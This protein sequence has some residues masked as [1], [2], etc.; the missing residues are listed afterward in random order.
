MAASHIQAVTADPAGSANTLVISMAAVGTGSGLIAVVA[1]QA[2]TTIVSI[3]D[4]AA[5]SPNAGKY[6]DL[7]KLSGSSYFTWGI[8]GL[9]IVGNPTSLTVTWNAAGD[10]RHGV[11]YEGAGLALSAGLD[12][13]SSLFTAASGPGTDAMT[14]GAITTTEDGDYA[15]AAFVRTGGG[16]IA[17]AGTGWGTFD[18][19]T[20]FSSE[21]QIQAAAG[22]L[23][24]T[25]TITGSAIDG[26][27]WLIAL[28]PTA[29]AGAGKPYAI[30]AQQ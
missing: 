23:A 26:H 19:T 15:V 24:G 29:A 5:G 22:S 21:H 28:K 8:Y 3:V 10:Y 11:L 6:V 25:A 4:N 7:G 14:S 13:F 16:T 20:G 18:L 2:D 17:S 9:N 12:G 30:Y 27:A 1:V